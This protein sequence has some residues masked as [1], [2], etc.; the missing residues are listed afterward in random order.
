MRRKI[1][2][3]LACVTLCAC[4]TPS[5]TPAPPTVVIITTTPALEALVENWIVEIP[6]SD[7]DHFDLHTLAPLEMPGAIEDGSV[8]LAI[9]GGT[10][11]ED[12]FATPLYAE[13]IAVIVHADNNIRSL[14]LDELEG[15]VSG[16][17]ANWSA[18][19]DA[20]AA[21]QPVIPL[22]ADETRIHFEQLVMGDEAASVKA[23]LAPTP[24]AMI[25]LVAQYPGA[26]GYLPFS[27]LTDEVRALRVD[28]VEP[29]S[30]NVRSGR[31]PLVLPVIAY[32][33]EEPQGALRN[34]LLAIQSPVETAA[35]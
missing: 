23:L 33:L 21:V 30:A 18:L 17:I 6:A 9:V 22:P 35:P 19:K 32:A 1:S 15:L 24:A 20:D 12:A 16:R 31:Y 7:I 2:L 14:S 34:W 28:N 3:A 26:I 11:P 25:Q 8:Q 10:P 5:L 29:S 4:S 27:S 13:G